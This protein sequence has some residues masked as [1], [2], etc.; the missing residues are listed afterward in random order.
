M[1]EISMKSSNIGGEG[2][3]ILHLL[4]PNQAS[5]TRTGIH[6]IG[7]SAKGASRESSN[8]KAVPKT[9][10]FCPQTSSKAPLLKT[11]ILNMEML[12]QCLHRA[13]STTRQCLWFRKVLCTLSQVQSKHQARCMFFISNGVLTARCLRVMVV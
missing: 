3:P 1:K 12:I 7:I 11:S 5:H 2:T 9:I 13:F 6:L 8:K 4:S 10:S